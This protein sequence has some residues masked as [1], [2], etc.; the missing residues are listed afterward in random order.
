MNVSQCD[1]CRALGALTRGYAPDNWVLV[2][3]L[4]RPG[5]AHSPLA[6]YVLGGL[7]EPDENGRHVLLLEVRCRVLRGE[8]AAC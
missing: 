5:S 7:G 2:Y 1:T 8:G 4:D 6:E 3:V